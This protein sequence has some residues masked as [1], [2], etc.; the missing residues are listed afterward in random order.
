[1][2][3]TSCCDSTVVHRFIKVLQTEG[4]FAEDQL[5]EVNKF[6]RLNP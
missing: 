1:M 2:K 3:I 6:P 4:L 5:G